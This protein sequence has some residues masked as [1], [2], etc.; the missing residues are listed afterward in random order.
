MKILPAVIDSNANTLFLSE[1]ARGMNLALKYFFDKKVTV[2][3]RHMCSLQHLECRAFELGF[4]QS[5]QSCTKVSV[6]S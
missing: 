1:M 4:S 2:R 3:C 6:S 5:R